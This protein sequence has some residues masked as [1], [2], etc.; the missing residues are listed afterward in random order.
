MGNLLR[1]ARCSSDGVGLI[2]KPHEDD[3]GCGAAQARYG[4]DRKFDDLPFDGCQDDAI[5]L[6]GYDLR[7]DDLTGFVFYFCN[8]YPLPPAALFWKVLD[9]CFF[10]DTL[11]HDGQEVS[12]FGFC[13]YDI[14]TD[15][16]IGPFEEYATYSHS[17]TGCGAHFLLG[18]PY[19][20]TF[21]GNEEYIILTA[22]ELGPC[23]FI[24][25]FQFDSDDA[26]SSYVFIF[27]QF[28]FFDRSLFG[29][30]EDIFHTLLLLFRPFE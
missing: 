9:G 17:V 2:R 18:K 20:F 7:Y 11:F 6:C 12:F 5:R 22:C 15:D 29:R 16:I 14:D 3:T 28:G 25:R 1:Q 19:G 30:H 27:R 4:I 23:Q 21:M 26:A 8:L 13:V 24:S 10:A